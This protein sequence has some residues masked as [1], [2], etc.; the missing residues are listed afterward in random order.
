M[1]KIFFLIILLILTFV[2]SSQFHQRNET[3]KNW[4]ENENNFISNST[5][6]LKKILNKANRECVKTMLKFS[7]LGDNFYTD[8]D[9]ISILITKS[10][11]FCV[12]NQTELWMMRA[13]EY[14]HE[15]QY[16]WYNEDES[17]NCLRRKIQEIEPYA[18]I[19]NDDEGKKL[20]NNENEICN[21]EPH[22]EWSH[23]LFTDKGSPFPCFVLSRNAV[24]FDNIYYKLRI[25]EYGH[26][27]EKRKKLE[28]E[29]I[30]RLLKRMAEINYRCLIKNIE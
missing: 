9:Y 11:E 22:L 18:S 8:D 5:N 21:V 28:M 15:V 23:N 13:N 14:L 17:V 1:N 2:E 26:L 7:E 10:F 12:E 27:S 29:N 4:F 16:G 25:I 3:L 24:K 6:S 20:Q 30:A 19:L